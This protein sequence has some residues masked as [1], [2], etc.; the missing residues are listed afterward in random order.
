[1]R[2]DFDREAARIQAAQERPALPEAE[3]EAWAAKQ[4]EF[5]K[6]K[7]FD[8]ANAPLFRAASRYF[9]RWR[10][11]QSEEPGGLYRRPEKGLFLIGNVGTGK[12]QA[13]KLFSYRFGIDWFKAEDF[14]RVYAASGENAFWD[15]VYKDAGG[16]IA[17]DDL[18][19]ER[20]L[21]NFGNEGIMPTFLSERYEFFQ[22]KGAFTFITSNLSENE[23]KTRYGE[24]VWSRI[25]QM[26]YKVSVGG[27]DRRKASQP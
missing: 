17:L 21:K 23:F 16:H 25:N 27:P 6:A 1:M 10:A 24:R 7:G 12:T 15:Y 9:G 18:G 11:S 13:L 19:A 3:V 2:F 22:A 8:D 4:A 26:C 20:D 14:V 5:L